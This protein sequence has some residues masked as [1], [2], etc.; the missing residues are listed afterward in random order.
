M[1]C[2]APAAYSSSADLPTPASPRT[3]SARPRP[4]R[5]SSIRLSGTWRSR[6]RSTSA[7]V[8]SDRVCMPAPLLGSDSQ[9]NSDLRKISRNLSLTFAATGDTGHR[10]PVQLISATEA[11]ARR[12]GTRT[13]L[14]RDFLVDQAEVDALAVTDD[15]GAAVDDDGQHVHRAHVDQ[16]T[17]VV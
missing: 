13:L 9:G 8:G 7:G 1:S 2:A 6:W 4:E 5:R 16:R 17:L 10:C 3:T 15:A 14:G 11:P 12:T